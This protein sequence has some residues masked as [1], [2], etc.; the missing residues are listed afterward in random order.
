MTSA[1]LRRALRCAGLAVA[2]PLFP[3]D[4]QREAPSPY[5]HGVLLTLGFGTLPDAF[6]S[7]CGREGSGSAG[8]G[9]GAAVL[10]RLPRGLVVQ[11]DA[12]AVLDAIDMGCDAILHVR[13]L[14]PGLYETLPGA[15]VEDGTPTVP[16]ARTTLRV[17][18]ETPPS[19][20]LLR[21]TVGGGAIW[22]GGMAPIAVATLGA[23]T[24]GRV[25]RYYA[26][27]EAAVTRVR[28]TERRE[29]HQADATGDRIVGVTTV[30]LVLRPVWL[31]LNVGVEIPLHR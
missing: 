14:G 17:G 26:E 8:P 16:L 20:P 29:R 1:P 10:A 13:N 11:G 15:V 27:L 5:R 6:T 7:R 12:H 4:A 3:A 19:L 21:A 23:G 22:T 31:T 25:Q 30:P 9:L 18:L 24:R 28:A 2:V